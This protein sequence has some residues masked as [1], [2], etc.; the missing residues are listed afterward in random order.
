[1]LCSNSCLPCKPVLAFEC[2][3]ERAF[4]LHLLQSYEGRSV[5]EWDR[6]RVLRSGVCGFVAHGP[7]SHIYY[8]ALDSW[9]A[10]MTVR[11]P[12]GADCGTAPEMG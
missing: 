2:L 8:L 7:L 11:G 5:G 4:L 1:M 12:A 3:F 9:F 10:Q 6:A